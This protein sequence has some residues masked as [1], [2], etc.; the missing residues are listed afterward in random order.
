MPNIT[1]VVLNLVIINVLLYFGT[2]MQLF[3]NSRVM[4]AL[5]NPWSEYFR[6]YQLVTHMFMHGSFNHLLFNM[7]SLVFLGPMVEAR[8]GSERFLVLY[9]V[10]GF[11]SAFLQIATGYLAAYHFGMG[12]E[13]D[14]P[15]LGASGAIY[16]VMAAF[17]MLFPHERLMLLFPPIPIRAPYF[18]LGLVAIDLFSGMSGRD[19]GVAHFAHVGGA[20]FGA[21]LIYYWR[22]RM[23]L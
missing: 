15:M 19:T 21:A 13:I 8:L 6:P 1:K 3:D 23:V 12:A 18:V 10:A 16:G 17:A 2:N 20:L 22:K 7:L 11:G 14:I 5:F 4:L 9:F